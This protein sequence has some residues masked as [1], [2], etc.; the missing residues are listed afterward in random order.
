ML[1]PL[2][3][4]REKPP[5]ANSFQSTT[6]TQKER[7]YNQIRRQI[8]AMELPG[9]T[10]VSTR[11]LARD[12]GVSTIPVREAI[13]QLVGEGLL[14]HRPGVG[15]FVMNPTRLEVKDIYELRMVLESHA[16]RKAA[17][18][19][20]THGYEQM[21]RSIELMRQLSRH[22]WDH[23]HATENVLLHKQW[24]IADATFHLAVLHRAGNQMAVKMV[25][26][27]RLMTRVFG[28]R[29]S[30]LRMRNLEGSL[31]E[32]TEILNA[33]EQADPKQASRLMRSHIRRGL[34]IAMAR[35]DEHL[36]TESIDAKGIYDELDGLSR[37]ITQIE[38]CGI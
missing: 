9:G 26:G 5:F 14:E 2:N 36:R 33:I 35:D 15:T 37:E 6:A 1:S 32:H 29:L 11:G 31:C 13:T 17:M 30:D 10:K 18:A 8:E 27:L 38:D 22:S 4:S 7:A 28:H 34:A 16:A 20:G 24:G 3:T 19:T 23:R 21:R 12:L 25:A